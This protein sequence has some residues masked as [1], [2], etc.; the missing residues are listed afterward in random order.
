MW[1]ETIVMPREEP[2][3]YCPAPQRDRAAVHAAGRAES[4]QFRDSVLSYL[5]NHELMNAVK[6]V[7]EPGSIA[8]VTL[9]CTSGVLERLQREPRF[10][11]G[12]SLSLTAY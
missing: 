10:E 2:A 6:W 9:H 5:R 8:M 7:S 12:R 11:A 3:H 4:Q 1:I